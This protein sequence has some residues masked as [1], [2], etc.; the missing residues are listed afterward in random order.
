ML[1]RPRRAAAAAS[2][3]TK[4][5]GALT[6]R[7]PRQAPRGAGASAPSLRCSRPPAAWKADWPLIVEMRAAGDAPVDT[8]GCDRLAD[9]R[10]SK[11]DAE[12]QCLVAA[13]L[14]SLT[15]D[16]MT[17]AAM[18]NLHRH[19]NSVANV[20][21][22][23]ETRLAKLISPVGFYATKAKNIRATAKIC[24]KHHGGKVPRTL[25]ELVALPGVGPKM[26]H[27]TMQS[28]FGAEEGICVDT[29]VHRIANALGWV[30]TRGPEE[31]RVAMQA[32]L[33]RRHWGEANQLL[34]GLG[35]L[36]QQ[37]PRRLVQRC[38][39]GRSSF[40]SLRLLARIGMKLHAGKFPELAEAARGSAP[41]RRLLA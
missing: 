18:S 29:H 11:Q 22:T 10:A 12:W 40:H 41:I 9:R 15:R 3:A 35:Q 4:A 31:T 2:V 24:L 13:M 27:L 34:V 30:Q 1:R 32:W 16:Q 19:G 37:E 8:I 20:A 33:P 14:S 38:L 23:T 28:A 5:S 25:E 17:A 6:K 7:R 26:A 39:A 36:Q 21:K